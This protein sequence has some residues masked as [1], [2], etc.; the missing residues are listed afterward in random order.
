MTPDPFSGPALCLMNLDKLLVPI[1]FVGKEVSVA[2]VNYF[3]IGQLFALLERIELL[4]GVFLGN[5]DPDDPADVEMIVCK[6]IEPS[7][8][9][10]KT[11]GRQAVRDAISF[12]SSSGD[13]TFHSMQARRQELTLPDSH[14]W[15]VFLHRIG[16]LLFGDD[17]N[18][19]FDPSK[20]KEN[21]DELAS[22]TVFARPSN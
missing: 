1:H 17:Y 15:P 22:E 3:V 18:I 10:A 20:Y 13:A 14:S 7:L 2:T 11:E 21:P 16:L 8:R 6:Y 4:D 12:Y 5:F 19:Q 9:E